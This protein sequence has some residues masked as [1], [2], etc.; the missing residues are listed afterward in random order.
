MGEKVSIP[1]SLEAGAGASGKVAVYTVQAGRVLHVTR[2]RVHFPK[3]TARELQAAFYYGERKV[4]PEADY[5]VGDDSEYDDPVDERWFSG[6]P[7]LLWYNN[8]GAAA[9]YVDGSL[10]GE[11]E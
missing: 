2:A 9:R 6:D 11:L 4:I 5:Y 1:F 7:V 8:T 3:D 10:E